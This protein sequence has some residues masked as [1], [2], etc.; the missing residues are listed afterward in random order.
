VFIG[1]PRGEE[2]SGTLHLLF[3]TLHPSVLADLQFSYL[4]FASVSV[5]VGEEW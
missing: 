1:I 4:S 3:T 2:Y 5:P